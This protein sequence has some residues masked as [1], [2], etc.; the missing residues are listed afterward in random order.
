VPGFTLRHV[1]R[2]RDVIWGFAWSPDG[3]Y[4]A[5]PSSDKAIRIWDARSGAC[6]R[7]LED[8]REFYS[9]AW[10]P[11]GRRLASASSDAS[12][13]LWDATNGKPLKTLKGHVAGV[14][15]R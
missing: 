7:T 4:L 12:I 13:R 2:G 3:S 10:S 14:Q 6:V 11:D 8:Y 5:S 9:V 15:R 1:L